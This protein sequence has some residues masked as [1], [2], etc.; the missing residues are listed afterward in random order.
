[1]IQRT[2][3]RPKSTQLI[4]T[5]QRGRTK[6]GAKGSSATRPWSAA[7]PVTNKRF[8]TRLGEPSVK[9]DQEPANQYITINY[10]QPQISNNNNYFSCSKEENEMESDY[11]NASSIKA[12]YATQS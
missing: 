9:T 7:H 2:F 4:T 11:P 10:N 12:P 5:G 8:G 6:K 1:M 3:D